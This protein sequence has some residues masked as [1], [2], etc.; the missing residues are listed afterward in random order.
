MENIE[1]RK[2]TENEI[3]LAARFYVDIVE[4]MIQTNT[5]Y[6]KWHK[7]YPDLNT[8]LAAYENGSQYLCFADGELAGAFVLNE[9]PA[10]AYKN[11]DWSFPLERGEY[12][13]IHTLAVDDRFRGRGIAAKMT[14]Y[15]IDKAKSDGYKGIRVDV[16]PD[17]FPAQKLYTKLGFVFAGEKDLER[18]IHDIPAFRLYEY[19]F[20]KS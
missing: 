16:V 11:G 7:D 12:L 14:G 8:V 6:P 13:V 15:C 9:D 2:C 19:N 1:I 4:K 18:G 5:N 17:N 3:K 10:G 20:Y